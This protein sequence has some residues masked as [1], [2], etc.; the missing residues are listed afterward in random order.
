MR[1]G[2]GGGG[3]FA[4]SPQH[5]EPSV[6]VPQENLYASA[7]PHSTNDSTPTAGV[8]TRLKRFALDLRGPSQGCNIEGGVW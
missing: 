2:K 7:F 8:W 6:F 3:R 4:S 1:C 5:E